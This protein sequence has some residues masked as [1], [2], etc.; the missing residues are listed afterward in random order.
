MPVI[1]IIIPVFNSEKYLKQCIESVINQTYAD[2]ELLLIND[3]STDY[4]GEICDEYALKDNRIKVFHQK[5]AGVS[6][7]RNLGLNHA[8]GEWITFVD[9]DDYVGIDFLKDFDLEYDLIL[10]NTYKSV[11]DKLIKFLNFDNSVHE[12]DD[13]LNKFRLYPN[14]SAPWAKYFKR[15]IILNNKIKFNIELNYGE[16]TLFNLTYLKFAKKILTTNKAYYYYRDTENGLSK[17][18][19]NYNNDKL[20][21]FKTEEALIKIN[22]VHFLKNNIKF[23]LV[24]YFFAIY[25]SDNNIARKVKDVEEITYKYKP[26][27]ISSLEKDSI[28]GISLSFFMKNGLIQFLFILQKFIFFVSK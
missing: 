8:L 9:S 2:F 3:G 5:N 14:F 17:A 27:L 16:D 24:R 6:A 12:L 13:F 4:S 1:S 10:L 18:K 21:F 7:A 19:F 28:C 20:F 22:N 26:Q 25:V 15:E 11:D 23:S